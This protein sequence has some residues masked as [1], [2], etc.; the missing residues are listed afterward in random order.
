MQN[1]STLREIYENLITDEDFHPLILLETRS[2]H[3]LYTMVAEGICCS[4][5]PISYAQH[6][7]NV[8]YFSIKQKT[9][10]EVCAS[11]KK[12][13]YLS[14]PTKYLVKIASDYWVNKLIHP[15]IQPSIKN[16]IETK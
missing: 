12:G 13:T 9:V 11:Y 16:H 4:V 1:G 3:N 7:D 15:N 2:C 14:N 5:I 8:A 10:W 6:N